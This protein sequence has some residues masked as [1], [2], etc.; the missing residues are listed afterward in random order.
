MNKT[1]A[2]K[3]VFTIGSASQALPL[4]RVI[5]RDIV[6]SSIDIAETRQRL[7]YLTDGRTNQE[8]TDE[9]A[10]E[11][12]SIQ[13]V[14][15]LQSEQVDRWIGELSELDVK[16]HGVEDGFVDFP[17]VRDG[18]E[19]CLCWQLGEPHVA[20]WHEQH[21]ACQLRKEVDLTMIRQSGD[22]NSELVSRN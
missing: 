3:Q 19:V 16:S 14:T 17:A 6:E 11:L 1:S 8:A 9:Y 15:D 5:V 13:Q 21:E 4:I 22:R 10:R 12:E 18:R 2:S 20:H 7:D